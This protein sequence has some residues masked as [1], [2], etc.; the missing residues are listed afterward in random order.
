MSDYLSR[1]VEREISAAPGVR[2]ALPSLFDSGKASAAVTTLE[3]EGHIEGDARSEISSRHEPL[4]VNALPVT[5]AATPAPR[6][7][8]AILRQSSTDIVGRPVAHAEAGLFPAESDLSP[9]HVPAAA[10]AESIV[11]QTAEARPKSPGAPAAQPVVRQAGASLAGEPRVPA[12]PIGQ[13]EP[14]APAIR[15]VHGSTEPTSEASA[16]VPPVAQVVAAARPAVSRV[17][18]APSVEPL[19]HSR[20]ARDDSSSSRPIHI[21]IGRIEVRAVHP[22]PEPVVQRPKPVSPKISLEEYLKQRNGGRR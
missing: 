10:A 21:T 5:T 4:A 13:R 9:R 2:P 16:A 11:G 3:T 14:I 12:P 19:R 15:S 7:T 22:P 8:E 6:E 18:P 1:A 17:S 20:V